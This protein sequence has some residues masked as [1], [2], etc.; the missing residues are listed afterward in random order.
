LE[1]VSV[2]H[3]RTA[4][5][6][7]RLLC[8]IIAVPA[9]IS[10]CVAVL[11]GLRRGSDFQWSGAYMLSHHID[12]YL[13][14]LPH[15]PRHLLLMNQV[16]NYLHE[17]YVFLMPLGLLPFGIAKVVWVVMNLLF[18]GVCVW[19]LGRTY[20]LSRAQVWLLALLLGLSTPFRVT[21]A[22]GQNALAVTLLLTVLLTAGVGGG[23]VLGLSYFKYSFSPILVCYLA[24]RRRWNWLATSAIAPLLGLAIFWMMVHGNI[25]REATE[26]FAVSRNNGVAFGAGDL[27]TCSNYLRLRFAL[28]P[29]STSGLSFALIGSVVLGAIVAL[30]RAE[31]RYAFPALICASLLLLVHLTYDYVALMI[32]LAALM[33]PQTREAIPMPRSKKVAV[34]VSIGLL[35]YVLPSVTRFTTV[36]WQ[37]YIV[38]LALGLLLLCFWCMLPKA[39]PATCSSECAP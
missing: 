24:M 1:E 9:I 39:V 2:L 29:V 15:D 38:F 10:I 35:W 5:D 11:H 32:P 8:G 7:I 26:P 13:D 21:V 6:R 3:G 28:T 30:R 17:L 18:A 36:I 14:S 37:G 23:L 25:L 31:D 19:L 12:P 34:G 27:M 33:S 20:G 22:T 4:E 16:P